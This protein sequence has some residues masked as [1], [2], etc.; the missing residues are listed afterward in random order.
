MTAI[1]PIAMKEPMI[2]KYLTSGLGAL[3]G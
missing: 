2:L 1:S 3:F